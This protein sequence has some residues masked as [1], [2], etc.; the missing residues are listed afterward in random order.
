MESLIRIGIPCK[1]LSLGDCEVLVFLSWSSTAAC[2]RASG[3]VSITAL[4]FGP[5]WLTASILARYA[6]VITGVSG[7]RKHG[8]VAHCHKINTGKVSF[9]QTLLELGYGCFIEI[10]IGNIFLRL[11]GDF[12]RVSL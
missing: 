11:L 5:L 3:F 12:D 10:W 9:P 4:S 8:A 2:A 7:R 6:C 1:T